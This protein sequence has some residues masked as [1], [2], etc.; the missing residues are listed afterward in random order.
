MT[1]S[2]EF[3]HLHDNSVALAVVEGWPSQSLSKDV[4]LDAGQDLLL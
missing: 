1:Q 2:R 3:A 4:L